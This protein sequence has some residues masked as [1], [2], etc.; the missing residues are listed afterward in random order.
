MTRGDIEYDRGQEEERLELGLKDAWWGYRSMKTGG[1]MGGYQEEKIGNTCEDHR[2]G[3]G[4][5][6]H[7]RKEGCLMDWWKKWLF[8]GLVDCGLV[9]IVLLYLSF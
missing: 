3:G 8:V 6:Y 1:G 5:D 2:E 9:D 7:R 4:R